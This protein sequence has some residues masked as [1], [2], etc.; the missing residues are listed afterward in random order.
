MPVANHENDKKKQKKTYY[1]CES[2]RGTRRFKLH[3]FF[4]GDAIKRHVTV[5][6]GLSCDRIT[7]CTLS[8]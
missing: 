3:K 2:W 1:R 6:I 7:N 4:N 5:F 8:V